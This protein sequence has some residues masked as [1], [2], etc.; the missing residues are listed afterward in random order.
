MVKKIKKKQLLKSNQ[1]ANQ[2]FKLH[3]EGKISSAILMYERVLEINPNETAVLNN[4]AI[5]LSETNERPKS[6]TLLKTLLKNEPKNEIARESIGRLYYEDGFPIEAEKNLKIALKINPKNIKACHLMAMSLS[7]RRQYEEA[8]SYFLKTLAIN[9]NYKKA[10]CNYG[11]LKAILHEFDEAEKLFKNTLTI[12]EN[13]FEA[14]LYLADVYIEQEEYITAKNYLLKVLKEK[15]NNLEI[16]SRLGNIYLAL[17]EYDLSIERHQQTI[18]I[19]HEYMDGY[20]FLAICYINMGLFKKALALL[21]KAIRVSNYDVHIYEN[22]AN[23]YKHLCE[24]DH[25]IEYCEKAIKI[26]EENQKKSSVGLFLQNLDIKDEANKNL[27]NIAIPKNTA[28]LHSILG[29]FLLAKGE[30]D[31]GWVEYQWRFNTGDVK[32]PIEDKPLWQG[33]QLD[34]KTLLIWHEQG[35]GDSIQ[36]IRFVNKINKGSG[37]LILL[38]DKKLTNLY[39]GIT[40]L[41]EIVIKLDSSLELDYH[42]PIASLPI[43][44]NNSNLLID[45]IPYLSFDNNRKEYWSNRFMNNKNL[46]VG[47]VWSGNPKYKAD[48][49]RS[50]GLD[51]VAPIF[52]IPNI[53]FYSL[54][55]GDGKLLLE[56]H[57]AAKKLIDFT[58]EIADFYD[59]AAFMQNLDL[60]I[61][62]DTAT[63][64]LAGALGIKTWCL[65]PYSPDW[66]WKMS[67]TSCD[68]YNTVYLIR[69]PK[70]K[71]WD[72]VIDIVKEK[73]ILLVNK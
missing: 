38:T 37:K 45:S 47:I 68:W 5:L 23:I 43:L 24:L 62:S 9:K 3:Q 31:R 10:I 52:D 53:D 63:V 7:S 42:F 73:L 54:Q 28:T 27:K 66:R 36:F 61:T 49:L 70:Y 12:D 33:E 16:L 58:D 26:D 72:S 35:F 6:Y 48:K 19:N 34:N 30:Y 41:D 40:C 60:V 21:N 18:D 25:A 57:P 14:K 4:L 1:L 55:R 13:Y 15:D 59:D 11:R 29:T 64:H 22:I 51:V 17:E 39:K 71:D 32:W 20:N 56:N 50:P 65:L 67:G 44:F 69:Q 8:E 46:K 2:A